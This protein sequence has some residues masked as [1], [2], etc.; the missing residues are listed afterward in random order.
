MTDPPGSALALINSS[1]SINPCAYRKA[2]PKCIYGAA[3]RGKDLLEVPILLV[4]LSSKTV[5]T[6]AY[7]GLAAMLRRPRWLIDIGRCG[8]LAKRQTA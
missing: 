1:C 4:I 2:S 5:K 6:E 3:R 7:T 8:H